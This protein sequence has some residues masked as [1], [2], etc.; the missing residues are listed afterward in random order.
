MVAGE[1]LPGAGWFELFKDAQ[2]LASDAGDEEPAGGAD[3]PS[4][5]GAGQ[6]GGWLC[7]VGGRWHDGAHFLG[8]REGGREKYLRRA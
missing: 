3:V 1:C 5:A 4:E 8:K 7:V 2:S 6:G